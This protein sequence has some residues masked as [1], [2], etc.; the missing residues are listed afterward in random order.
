MS[1]EIRR[2]TDDEWEDVCRADGR[3][4][5]VAYTTEE[6]AERRP[7]HDMTRFRIA[8]DD[9]E[10]VSTAGSYPFDVT[11][12]GGT[13]VPMGGVTWVSTLATHRR[14]GIMRQVVEA[15]HA[16][17][18]ERGEPLASLWASEGSIY[19]HLQ[20]GVAAQIRM[21]TIDPRRTGIRAEFRPAPNTVRYAEGEAAFDAMADIWERFRRGRA[22]E[23]S[24]DPA[25]EEAVLA[26][27]QRP[28][29]AL[30]AAFYLLHDD[31]YAIYR[32]EAKWNAGHP[33][34]TMQV[35]E[36]AAVTTEAHAALWHALLSVDLIGEIR[37]SI[38]PLDDPLPF[39][40][41]NQR[42]LRTTDLNDSIWVN[43]RDASICFGARSYRT[44][45]RLVVDVDGTRWAIEGGP[46]GGSCRRVR[47]RPDLVTSH[48]W[49]SA[50]L[51]GGTLPSALVAG[52]RMTA[53]TDEVLHRADLF[54]PTS[55]A[56]YCQSH[57]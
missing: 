31:G 51:Y 4:F 3:A 20:Y 35:I 2:P 34:H 53:R 45:D 13:C 48:A 5:G 30:S 46:D 41:E 18:D 26:R 27:R 23:I 57:Y 24:H 39:L 44:S 29:G 50:L 38:I 21:T 32:I 16:D 8:V 14:R 47:T 43:V 7:F 6:M 33:A 19:E 22:G 1:I 49:F 36:F 56:P 10:I 15:V 28:E 25:H 9:G 37:S 55:L 11:L 52:R 54:F 40:L 42:A 12:P 17:I